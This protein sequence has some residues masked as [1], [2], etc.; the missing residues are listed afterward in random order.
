VVSKRWPGCTSSTGACWSD[1]IAGGPLDSVSLVGSYLAFRDGRD[2]QL[3]YIA[4]AAEH[5]GTIAPHSEV[6]ELAWVTTADADRVTGAVQQVMA[7]LVDR[8]L[9]D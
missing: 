3:T 1:G 8:G 2:D 4:Y 5:D 9:L 6:E 7:T